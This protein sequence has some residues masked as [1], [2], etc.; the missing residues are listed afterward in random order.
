V[1]LH[2]QLAEPSIIH[3]HGQIPPNRLDGVPDEPLPVIAPGDSRAFRFAPTPG[4]HWMHSHLPLQGIGLLATPLIV[5]R[6][7]ELGE[8]RQEVVMFLHDLSF[9]N[10]EEVMA[11]IRSGHDAGMSMP[12]MTSGA[13]MGVDLN[14]HDWDAYVAND[15][16]LDDPEV[17]AVER[18]GRI[19]LRV[20]NAASATVFLIDTGRV[21]GRLVAVDGNPVRP[22]DGNSFGVAMGQRL[23]ILLDLPGDNEAWPILALREGARERAGMV[24]APPGARVARIDPVSAQAAPAF[25]LDQE[26]RLEAIESLEP[27][28]RDR[29]Q[30]IV[31]GGGMQ[32]Y[33]W[34]LNDAVWGS[35]VPIDARSGDRVEL[36]FRNDT[37]MAHPMHLHG[38]A[39]QVVGINK[40][41]LAGARR[42]TVHVPPGASVGIA[43]N[44]GEAASWMLHCHHTPH[45]A[46]GM[47][48]ELRIRT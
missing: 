20:I 17:I 36:I 30:L 2:N 33:V 4:T 31:L 18:G 46:A 22:V 15:R 48:S 9:S 47:I 13:A 29:R 8:D 6:P 44:A 7:E 1:T 5:R 10:P 38:H 11:Q 19:R 12:G 28:P 45:Q 26:L 35:H 39:F 42:D 40:R 14:D 34:T 25:D 23:D 43:F 41:T 24:L 37:M 16:T 27:R 3:W 32:P 21:P